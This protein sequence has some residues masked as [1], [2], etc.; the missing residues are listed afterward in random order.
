MNVT[1]HV[2]DA[3]ASQVFNPL[4]E[5][6]VSVTGQLES[7]RC[8]GLVLK[9]VSVICS[10]SAMEVHI[11]A[12][13]FDLGVPVNPEH[14]T[15]GERCGVTEASSEEFILHAALMDCGTRYLVEHPLLYI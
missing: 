13:L 4:V 3:E 15:L 14:L 12:D 2:E 6:H 10:P 9:T 1:Q 8:P 5:E 11:K 7:S